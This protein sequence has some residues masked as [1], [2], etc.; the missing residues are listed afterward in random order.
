MVSFE[1][2]YQQNTRQPLGQGG[3]TLHESC[4]QGACGSIDGDCDGNNASQA[5]LSVPQPVQLATAGNLS[6]QFFSL[7]LCE[8]HESSRHVLNAR[9]CIQLSSNHHVTPKIANLSMGF[10]VRNHFL[11][12][13]N[14]TVHRARAS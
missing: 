13:N 12:S 10:G 7:R 1:T 11:S 5:Q 4:W 3:G 6:V 14:Q 2:N 8:S 9:A